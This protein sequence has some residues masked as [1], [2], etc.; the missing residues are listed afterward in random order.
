M[1]P[2]LEELSSG[3]KTYVRSIEV[4]GLFGRHSQKLEFSPAIGSR[5]GLLYGSNGSGKTTVL[6][7]AE[8][9]LSP[10]ITAYKARVYRLVFRSFFIRLSN[11]LV[12]GFRRTGDSVIGAFEMFVE[13]GANFHVEYPERLENLLQDSRPEIYELLTRPDADNRR[14][15]QMQ[16]LIQDHSPNLV[17][18]PADRNTEARTVVERPR[19]PLR[20]NE[21]LG[22]QFA[23]DR[24]LARLQLRARKDTNAAD[25][26]AFDVF[27]SMVRNVASG[28]QRPETDITSLI[29]TLKA[30]IERI[31]TYSE[32]GL[33]TTVDAEPLI[34]TLLNVKQQRGNVVRELMMPYLQS[35][36]AKLASL[37]AIYHI[38]TQFVYA[39]NSF[40][41]GKS[42]SLDLL[43]GLRIFG[44]DGG[45]LQ[46][47][48]L[49]SGERQLLLL[50]CRCTALESP[51]NIVLI[52]EPELSLNSE[53]VRVLLRHLL[54]PQLT[55]N[56]QFI[57][58][59]HS[60][61]LLSQYEDAVVELKAD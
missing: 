29:E 54:N 61:E 45:A 4:E 16:R 60:I 51:S 5:L 22:L 6:R 32:I 21:R 24:L 41:R 27:S 49:S 57:M 42:I 50:F 14:F 25:S 39:L 35:Q 17:V 33:T 30:Q 40:Y 18:L 1:Q 31:H 52:D 15:Q 38:V 59:T 2:L 23:I 26:V 46:P 56:V 8:S 37:D 10:S 3:P 53:W 9:L 36:E 43:N 12:I 19:V 55:G 47:G 28:K 58:A 34:E 20:Q 11:G 44:G 48:V 13:G 7:L